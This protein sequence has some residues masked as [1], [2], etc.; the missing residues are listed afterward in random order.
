MNQWISYCTV[1]NCDRSGCLQVIIGKPPDYSVSEPQK[2]N[3]KIICRFVGKCR[4][5]LNM[6]KSFM[7]YNSYVFFIIYSYNANTIG[8]GKLFRRRTH[9]TF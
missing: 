7:V 3:A 4:E 1:P 2:S 6:R 5:C 9:G 8:T